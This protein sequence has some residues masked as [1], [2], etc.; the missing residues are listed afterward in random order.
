MC[1]VTTIKNIEVLI[2]MNK[3]SSCDKADDIFVFDALLS[4]SKEIQQLKGSQL[5][6][7]ADIQYLLEE[8]HTQWE[9]NSQ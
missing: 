5:I 8:T 3:F 2:E 1:L 4:I 7:M 9:T 6:M